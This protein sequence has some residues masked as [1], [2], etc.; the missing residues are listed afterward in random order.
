VPGDHPHL[1]PAQGR[2]GGQGDVGLFGEFIP[3]AF[4]GPHQAIGQLYLDVGRLLQ[5]VLRRL[6]IEGEGE[7]VG[8]EAAPPW[9]LPDPIRHRPR[10]LPSHSR[11]GQPLPEQARQRPLHQLLEVAFQTAQL[12]LH[13]AGL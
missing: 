7:L 11:G 3:A 13:R 2:I 12:I 4:G 6:R 9:L 5:Q 1:E 8:R 10:Q